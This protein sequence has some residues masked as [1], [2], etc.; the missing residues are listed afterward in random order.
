VRKVNSSRSQKKVHSSLGRA[1]KVPS[2]GG[3]ACVLI[4]V[5]LAA[6]VPETAIRKFAAKEPFV[7]HV[8]DGVTEHLVLYLGD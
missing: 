6:C 8:D 4:P 5:A 7:V 3:E 1:R 2:A